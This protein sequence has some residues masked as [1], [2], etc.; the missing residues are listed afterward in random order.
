MKKILVIDDEPTIRFLLKEVINEWGYDFIEACE[1]G[2]CAS[3]LTVQSEDT[4]VKILNEE[5]LKEM[6]SRLSI[7]RDVL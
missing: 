7:K 5:T 6:K 1:W 4:V 2:L 3:Y